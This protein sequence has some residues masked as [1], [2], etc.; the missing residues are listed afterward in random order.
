MTI[1][2]VS[3]AK[4]ELSA[5]LVMVE[6]GEEVMIARAGK[7]VA[8]L[9]RIDSPTEPRKLGALAG[10]IWISADFDE[11]DGELQRTF[12]EGSIEPTT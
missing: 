9:T 4:A 11:P 12:C 3:E 5:L 10:Q 1:R 2:N 8:K 6:N 7:P